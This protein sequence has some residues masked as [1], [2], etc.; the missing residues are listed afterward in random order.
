M[1]QCRFSDPS[2][3]RGSSQCIS[4]ELDTCP[5]PLRGP[6]LRGE[7]W[8]GTSMSHS[9]HRVT[10]PCTQ[11]NGR[12]DVLPLDRDDY[13]QKYGYIA[14]NVPGILSIARPYFNYIGDLQRFHPERIV[15]KQDS[16]SHKTEDRLL[17]HALLLS[18]RSGHYRYDYCRRTPSIAVF[19]C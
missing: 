3:L 14:N 19:V 4:F 2:L 6:I 5:A 12:K 8:S 16:V 11:P 18:T 17:T 7:K 15:T 9:L 1:T 10:S 13:V